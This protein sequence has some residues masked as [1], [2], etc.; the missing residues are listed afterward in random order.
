M[1]PLTKRGWLKS[2]ALII[3]IENQTTEEWIF[4]QSH[5]HHEHKDDLV[6]ISWIHSHVGGV[7]CGFSSID[8]HTQYCYEWSSPGILGAVFEIDKQNTCKKFVF[9]AEHLQKVKEHLSVWLN[10]F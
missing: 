9:L 7:T 6:L 4:N 1:Q 10:T 3:G 5:A 2:T 8:M